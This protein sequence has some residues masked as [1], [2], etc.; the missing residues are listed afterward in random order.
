[1]EKTQALR[2]RGY[3]ANLEKIRALPVGHADETSW[4]EN[5]LPYWV[6]YAGNKDLAGY[7]WEAHRSTEA[8][9]KLLGAKFG[10]VLVAD[11]FASYNGVA[12]PV[13]RC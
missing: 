13:R 9:Q 6:W 7:L 11:A 12:P 2:Q 4:R 5:G 3:P 1:M 8:A 10:G